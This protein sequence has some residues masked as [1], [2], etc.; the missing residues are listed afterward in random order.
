MAERRRDAFVE[1]LFE[2]IIGA[3]VVATVYLGD[4]LGLY[5]ALAEGGPGTPHELAERTGTHERYT[6]EWLE[7]EVAKGILAAEKQREPAQGGRYG[8]PARH[9]E[10]LLVR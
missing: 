6:R 2:K 1:D 3:M 9:A 10:G 8:P 7:E 5:Q 4:R